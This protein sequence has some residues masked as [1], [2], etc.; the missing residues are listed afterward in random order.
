M[1]ARIIQFLMRFC[2]FVS[3]LLL[4][5]H[6]VLEVDLF[7]L[8]TS[9]VTVTKSINNI[10]VEP[11][12]FFKLKDN[13]AWSLNDHSFSCQDTIGFLLTNDNPP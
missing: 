8:I 3:L 13:F 5:L 9:H 12:N 10:L 1:N 2:L 4:W 6:K 11:L 7:C